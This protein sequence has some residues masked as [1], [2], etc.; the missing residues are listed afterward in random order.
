MSGVPLLLRVLREPAAAAGFSLPEWDL[1]LRQAAVAS[2]VPAL[3]T[4]LEAAGVEA[5]PPARAHLDWMQALAARH[6][7][8]VRWEVRE[9]RRALDGL[10]LPVILLKGAAYALSGM[11]AARGRM[12][13][14]IDILV[15][16][17]RLDAVE[18]ALMMHGWV[19]TQHDAY[20]QRYYRTWMHELPPM[21]NVKRETVIDVHHAILPE[22]ARARPDSGKLRAAALAI[23]G[24]DGL[25]TLAP[26]DMVLHSA[27][28]LFHE[29][30]LDNGLRDLLDIHRLL[31]HF[32]GHPG[33]WTALPARALELQV[34]RSLYYA[35][36]YAARLLATPVP[37]EALAAL[38]GVRPPPALQALIDALFDRAL[39]PNHDSCRG[40]LTGTA[41][42]LLYVRSHWLR[43]P[44]L[45]LARHLLH[46]A[47]RGDGAGDAG[48]PA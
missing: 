17:S 25:A 42:Y 31:Q 32:G 11:P 43:M 28:H 13:S 2:L 7:L 22:T 37:P 8:A 45:L 19:S 47:V 21:Q 41:R 29:G 48:Q 44:P 33:F 5:P 26:V 27:V 10:G 15:P 9:I 46:K 34:G 1:L 39:L 40:P 36:H 6:A 4:M 23:P 38:S 20:D 18:A 30:E 14:D 35:L 24:E 16:K 3:R 12:F